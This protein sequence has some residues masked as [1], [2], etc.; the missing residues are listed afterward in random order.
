VE[1]FI[2]FIS[3]SHEINVNASNKHWFSLDTTLWNSTCILTLSLSY[4][5]HWITIRLRIITQYA[6]CW[7][8]ERVVVLY[9]NTRR[10]GIPHIMSSYPISQEIESDMESRF[11]VFARSSIHIELRVH[12]I[13]KT[14]K[15]WFLSIDSISQ[16][17]APTPLGWHSLS[18]SYT[19]FSPA[20]NN[21]FW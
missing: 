9:S 20:A 10:M 21:K 1:A 2:T 4:I 8:S 15:T 11:S 3:L 13:A 17:I 7:W 12:D 16:E 19:Y 5:P 14:R 6:E 18:F